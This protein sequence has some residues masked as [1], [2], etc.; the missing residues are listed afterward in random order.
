MNRKID[1]QDFQRATRDTPREV[2]RRIILALMRERGPI[3]RADL[4]RTMGVPRGMIT[5]LVRELLEKGLIQEGGTAHAPRG[6]RP[7]LLQLRSHD[8]FA[9]GV[10]IRTRRTVLTLSDFGGEEIARE[11]FE[12]LRNPDTELQEVASRVKALLAT[13][14]AEGCEG[15]GVVVPG[16]VDSRTGRVLNAPTLGWRDVDLGATL[17]A[18]LGRTVYVER[19]AVACAMA[20]MWLGEQ[21]GE[22]TRDFVYLI[23]DEGV[24]VGLIVNGQPVRGR[25]FTAGE[26]GHIPLDLEGPPCSCG[27]RGCFE[28]FTSESATVERYL[29]TGS[30]QRR[31]AEPGTEEGADAPTAPERAHLSVL[32]LANRARAGDVAAAEALSETGRY[33]GVGMAAII[34]ALNPARIVVGG[35]ITAGWEW[36]E[37]RARREIVARTLTPSAAGT[38]FLVDP[39]YPETRLRGAVALVVAPA[40]AAPQVA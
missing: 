33:L 12:T 37:E 28:A 2:N 7:V 38:P 4:A 8:R 13:A 24:G 5:T 35:A 15:V 34:N 14:G 3:S 17:E 18:R 30:Q 26:F 21:P 22:R 16:M 11:E 32:E 29:A 20:R 39:C 6:R 25:N 1:T 36:A 40:F 27:Q 23:V 19:D 10:D 9:V 31:D